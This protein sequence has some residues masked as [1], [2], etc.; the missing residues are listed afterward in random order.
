MSNPYREYKDIVYTA[1]TVAVGADRYGDGTV[2]R[3]QRSS[4]SE[5]ALWMLKQV[6]L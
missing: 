4:D 1:G 6:G 5:V 3:G 2:Y